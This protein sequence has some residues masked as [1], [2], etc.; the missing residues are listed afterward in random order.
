M[1]F[2]RVAMYDESY[3]ALS[4]MRTNTILLLQV[5]LNI[6]LYWYQLNGSALTHQ[7]L[8]HKQA[9][10]QESGDGIQDNF[11]LNGGAVVC[12]PHRGSAA[13]PFDLVNPPDTIRC[14]FV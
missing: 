7:L 3:A 12:T 11:I 5:R 2:G 8:R 13:V 14:P 6:F 1:I 4:R 9:S 10:K